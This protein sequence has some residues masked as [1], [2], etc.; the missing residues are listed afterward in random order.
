MLKLAEKHKELLFLVGRPL[1]PLYSGIMRLRG[2]LYERG[3]FRRKRLPCLTISVGNITLG[4]TGKTPHVIALVEWFKKRGMRPAVVSRGYGGRVGR[5]PL[6]VSAKTDPSLCGDEPAMLARLL[7]V[8]VG[9]GSHR[10]LS[11]QLLL[12]RYGPDLL[13]L[14]DGFQHMRLERDIDICL[15]DSQ[16]PFGSGRVFPGGDLREPVAA[17]SRAHAIVLT[18]S[19]SGRERVVKEIGHLVGHD[20]IFTSSVQ[21]KGLA[22]ASP[23][24]WQEAFEAGVNPGKVA[25]FCG[26]ANPGSFEKALEEAGFPPVVLISF[27]DHH[28]YT[29]QDLHQI[30]VEAKK[31]GAQ[32]L[33]TTRKDAVKLKDE[34]LREWSMPLFVLEVDVVLE[35]RFWSWLEQRMC[36]AVEGQAIDWSRGR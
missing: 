5:G 19:S 10:Y 17:L 28:R 23:H 11:A 24:G 22:P 13:I 26:I 12:E 30:E 1:S 2:F 6:L 32:A 7:G 35:P 15:L 34:W 27:P 29:R 18:R 25:A 9:V 8:P 33:V 36:Q 16:H 3:I 14:D 31:Q 21:V 4:G 20:A